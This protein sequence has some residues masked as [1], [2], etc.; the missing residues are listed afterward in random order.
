MSIELIKGQQLYNLLNQVQSGGFSQLSDKN[1]LLLIDARSIED[2]DHFHIPT[3]IRPRIE[4]DDELNTLN[5]VLPFEPM[6]ECKQNIVVYDGSTTTL[7]PH[8]DRPA[9]RVAMALSR[10]NAQVPVK[11]LY[12]GF[13]NFS[14]QYPFMRTTKITFTAREL[15]AILIYPIE[16][17]SSSLYL[18]TINQAQNTKIRKNLKLDGFIMFHDNDHSYKHALE[19]GIPGSIHHVIGDAKISDLENCAFIDELRI[20]GKTVLVCCN[21]GRALSAACS[22]YYMIHT[23]DP[24]EGLKKEGAI[25]YIQECKND[26]YV[27]GRAL[28]LIK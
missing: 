18:G 16:I 2:Y 15:D 8:N 24:A 20:Q 28:N 27:K 4:R 17:F 6:I 7:V 13:Q 9:I 11:V 3:A 23:T 12:G 21:T 14:S 10:S 5:M 1:Y 25:K 22:I 26:I 19:C